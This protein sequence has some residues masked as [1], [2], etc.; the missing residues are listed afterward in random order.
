MSKELKKNLWWSFFITVISVLYAVA[1]NALPI[2]KP[3]MWCT[4]VSCPIFF[5]SNGGDSR[6]V[7]GLT[8]SIFCGFGYGLLCM[9]VTKAT[10]FLGFNAAVSLGVFVSVFLACA[11]HMG[12][13]AGTVFGKCPMAFAAFACC[14]ANGGENAVAVIGTMIVGLFLGVLF[15]ETG[16]WSDRI[17]GIDSTAGK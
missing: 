16:V 8:I 2:A 4:Y 15:M 12:F 14:F 5:L 1:Y 7:P 13:G 6:E 11:V 17:V 3:V 9:A 10:M